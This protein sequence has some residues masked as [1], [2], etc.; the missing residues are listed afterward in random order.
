M[1]RDDLDEILTFIGAETLTDEEFDSVDIENEDNARDVYEALLA[2]INSRELVSNMAER[3]RAY[4]AAQGTTFE[5]DN[6]AKSNIFIGS[7]L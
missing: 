3:L 2:V 6:R 7:R 5:Q 4:Y 1:L